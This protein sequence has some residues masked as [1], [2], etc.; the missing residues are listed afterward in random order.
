[1][2]APAG[3]GPVLE[4]RRL[5]GGW[6]LTTVID[7]ISLAL[8][9][10]EVVAMVGRNGVGKSTLLE[11]IAGRA[12]RQDGEIFLGE[13]D[14]SA[15]PIFQ[16]SRRG[17]GFVP[18]QREVFP[19][20]TV[21]EHLQIAKRPGPWG[22]GGVLELFPSLAGRLRSL[23]RELSGGE[24]QMLA[25]ARALI[26]N[27]VVLLMDEPTEGLA[28]VVVDQLV[29]ALERLVNHRRIA[30]LL[31]EQRIEIALA[32]SQRCIV[33]DRG[34]IVL[35][36]DSKSLHGDTSRLVKHMGFD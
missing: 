19:S 24:Q 18:Q 25:I 20:L 10:G 13:L 35:E 30:V 33:L 22:L 11:L 26:G 31:V 36:A 7:G 1:M 17:L 8:R 16:R 21:G 29:G 9:R 5:R 6:G 23:G 28:P 2:K 27:P 3:S 4:T 15:M 14:V 12:K 32:L 34:R